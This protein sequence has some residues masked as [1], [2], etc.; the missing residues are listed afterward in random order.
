MSN[1]IFEYL[2]NLEGESTAH[3]SGLKRVF[4][5]NDDVDSQLTQFA[6]GTFLPGEVCERHLH[7]TME[8]LF[9]FISGEGVYTVGEDPISIREGTF[10]RIP[11][12]VY[13]E[14]LNSGNKP[15]EFIYFGVAIE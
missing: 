14:L 9:Y 12:G 8:E 11:A 2:E 3:L 15:L 4:L 7:P 13:H 1:K 10:L 6:Y 5:R